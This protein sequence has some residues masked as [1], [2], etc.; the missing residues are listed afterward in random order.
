ME[1]YKK[2]KQNP[3]TIVKNILRYM[4]EIYDEGNYP[5]IG[6]IRND[7]PDNPRISGEFAL[8]NVYRDYLTIE[9]IKT[10]NAGNIITVE[11][12]RKR[13]A[14]TDVGFIDNCEETV[15]QETQKLFLFS[16]ERIELSCDRLEHYT[17]TKA[18]DFQEH[19]LITNYQIHMEIFKEIFPKAVGST[20]VCQMPAWHVKKPN[21]KG[22]T[23]INMGVGPANAK[24]ITDQIAVLRPDCMIMIGHCGGLKNHQNIGDFVLADRFIRDDHVLDAVLAKE[25]PVGSTLI[26]N[27]LLLKEI[28]NRKMPFRVGTIFT[29][30]NRDWEYKVSHYR[31]RFFASRAHGIDMESSVICGQGF[32]YK[33]PHATLL[34][35]SDKPLHGKPKLSQ[36]AQKFYQDSKRVHVEIAIEAIKNIDNRGTR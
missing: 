15:E 24:T 27:T 18:D 36:S 25:I 1:L 9:F 13:Q 14:K 22:I 10:L 7:T 17:K 8:P 21:K 29:T 34:M 4:Q 11:P 32:R 30:N 28:Q 31:E 33:I 6:I 2:D 19:I 23:M 26:I 3:N 35:V 5:L 20:G 16:P 12:G